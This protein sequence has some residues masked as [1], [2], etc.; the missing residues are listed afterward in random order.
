MRKYRFN[1]IVCFLAVCLMVN[2]GSC[3]NL[4]EKMYSEIAE[5]NYTYIEG[6]ATRLLG[7]AY[8]NLRG[9]T[10]AGAGLGTCIA[11]AISSDEAVFPANGSG[12]NDGGTFHRMHQHKW[13]SEQAHVIRMWELFY[14]GAMLCNRAIEM[15]GK[16]DFPIASYENRDILLAEA[17]TLRAF[18]YWY[19]LDNFGDVPL[20]TETTEERPGKTARKDIYDFVVKE[21]KDVIPTLS[22]EKSAA[23]YGRFNRWAAKAL[24]ANVYLNAEVYAGQPQWEA[25]KQE[26]D[27][28]IS[29]GQYD[30]EPDYKDIFKTNNENSIETIFVIPYDKIQAT[31]FNYHLAALHGANQK[32]YNMKAT[33]WGAGAYKGTPQFIDTYDPEDGRLS[34]TWL[35]GA[36]YSM[37]GTPV[38]GAYDMRDKPLIFINEMPD[39]IFTSEAEG[40]RFLKYEVEMEAEASLSNDYVLFRLA[41]VYLMKAECLLRTGFADD[42]AGIVTKVRER[43]FKDN[44]SK[45]IVTGAQLQAPSGYK[46]GVVSNFVL[47]PQAQQYPEQFGRFYDELGWELAG[48]TFR[49]RDMIRFGHFTKAEWLSHTPNGDYRTVFPIPQK[50]VDSN[51]KLEQNPNYVNQ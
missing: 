29:S 42:A 19:I 49:R 15:I 32:T 7:A 4:D 44:P 40:Y 41:Q 6:D 1:I 48:E 38:L 36:Q 25:C 9:W 46:Y 33:P 11:Q 3:T 28:I 24:L 21:L 18:Y 50:E 37:D 13:N 45:A 34:D 35:S 31:G 14:K 27:D 30:L 51:P 2:L 22:P 17:R 47:T 43:A 26:C 16:S 8:D 5:D 23:N 20:V 12:W 39:G 10:D